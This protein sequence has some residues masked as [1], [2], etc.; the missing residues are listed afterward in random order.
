MVPRG[1]PAGRVGQRC[2]EARSG[3]G[4]DRRRPLAAGQRVA[5]DGN[6]HISGLG[7]NASGNTQT[8]GNNT[9]TWDGES[10]LKSAAGVTYNYEGDGRRAAKAGSKLYWY[11]LAA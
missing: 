1:D 8:D 2:R 7:Y 3:A 5:A 11:G 6:N 4:R 10:Q 9:Y